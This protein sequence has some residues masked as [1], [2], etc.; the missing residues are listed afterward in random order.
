MADSATSFPSR[1][2]PKDRD[3]PQ[4]QEESDRHPH[5]YHREEPRPHNVRP[6]MRKAIVYYIV[7]D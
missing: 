1:T 3:E 4:R 7:D 2:D 5:E 6:P